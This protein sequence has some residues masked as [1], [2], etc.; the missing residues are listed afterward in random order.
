MIKKNKNKKTGQSA[1]AAELYLTWKEKTFVTLFKLFW[2]I[3]KNR[4]MAAL[5][6]PGRNQEAKSML[7]RSRVKLWHIHTTDYYIPI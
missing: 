1:L 6:F 4:V 3:E 5:L 2:M 7:I